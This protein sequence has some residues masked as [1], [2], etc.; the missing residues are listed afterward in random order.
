MNPAVRPK[1]LDH[2]V[3][4][5]IM[6]FMSRANV[7]LYRSTRGV[8]GSTWRVGTAFPRGVALLLLTVTG[9][10]SG[11]RF[12]TPLIY[13]EDGDDLVV[14]ASKGGLPADPDWY[15]NLRAHPEV[16]VQV[17]A[18]VEPRRARIATAAERE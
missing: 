3:V 6:R 5:K 4:P 9:R 10:K 13:L 16:E 18:R 8:L 14:V 2:P 17:G 12:T 15:L 11:K 7:W 1:G